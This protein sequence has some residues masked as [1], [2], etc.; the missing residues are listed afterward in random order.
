MEGYDCENCHDEGCEYCALEELETQEGGSVKFILDPTCASRSI[1]FNKN[2]PNAIYT[3]IRK[4]EKGFIKDRP[5]F[6]IT[7]DLPGLHTPSHDISNV[8]EEMTLQ[9]NPL[10]RHPGM[11]QCVGYKKV[12]ILLG[13]EQAG[14]DHD[15][16]I[17]IL[18]PIAGQGSRLGP[19]DLIDPLA[20]KIIQY[21][22]IEFEQMV[23]R[24][25]ILEK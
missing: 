3:D 22:N 5:N 1:W 6:E 15:R 18:N 17:E 21:Q 10:K 25:K 16:T 8:A 20:Q 24:G 7:P 23:F 4:E 13:A 9:I 19:A 12:E 2:H 14:V 11:L